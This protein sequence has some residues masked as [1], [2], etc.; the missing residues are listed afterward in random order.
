MIEIRIQFDPLRSNMIEIRIQF[1]PATG[2]V[3]AQ[4]P[5][6]PALVNF[7]LDRLKAK[8]LELPL[9]PRT[10]EIPSPEL[11]KVLTNGG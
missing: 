4:M 1:D 3:G 2:E 7:I 8:V 5:P 11:A 10:V 9:V 6:N